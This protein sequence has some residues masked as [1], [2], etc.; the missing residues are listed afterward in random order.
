MST[1][2]DLDAFS[3]EGVTVNLNGQEIYLEPPHMSDILRVG[4]L[5]NKLRSLGEEEL[6]ALEEVYNELGEAIKKCAP[7]LPVETLNIVQLLK[8]VSIL[9][10]MATPKD[11]KELDAK[12]ITVNTDPK[13]PSALPT[14]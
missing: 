12:G 10:D 1:V 4:V 5:S 6:E 8:L 11:I 3:P 9:M 7:A 13:A 14:K 2:I